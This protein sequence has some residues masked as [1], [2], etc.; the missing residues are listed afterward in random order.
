MTTKQRE[1]MEYL[2]TVESATW[3]QIY[4]NVSWGYYCSQGANMAKFLAK[5]VKNGS[6]ERVKKGVFKLSVSKRS[7]KPIEVNQNQQTLF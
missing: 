2:R 7:G 1:V 5:M 6:I 4:N 3:Q